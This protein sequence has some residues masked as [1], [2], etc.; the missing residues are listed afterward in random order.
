M[1]ALLKWLH[2]GWNIIAYG[3]W[4]NNILAAQYSC[5][6]M[7]LTI[8][9]HVTPLSVGMSVNMA[10]HPDYRG[11]GLIKQVSAPVYQTL[12]AQRV[13]AGVGFSNAAGVK[14]DQNS[15]GYGYQVIGQLLPSIG[16]IS[17]LHRHRSV[18]DFYTADSLPDSKEF[19]IYH[20]NIHFNVTPRLIAH[21]FAHHP[22]RR[23]KFGIWERAGS[24][25]GVVIYQETRLYGIPAVSLFAVYTDDLEGLL[26]RWI[27]SLRGIQ[28]IDV[29]T[30]PHSPIRD[31]L[32]GVILCIP[33][34][35]RHNPYYLT[36]KPLS[37]NLPE[38]L[39]DF[40]Q[41]DCIGGDIL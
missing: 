19:A 30:T 31:A 11:R 10:T 3:A 40:A 18:S 26:S 8:P 35:W 33:L 27:N 34:R 22:F 14:V 16:M 12:K 15:K 24:I 23:Y 38:A 20:S 7:T 1:I 13:S 37:E 39:F 21:R 32:A 28:M 41:W 17:P 25:H 29:L 2:A 36:L 5:L 6:Q 4:D 9:G